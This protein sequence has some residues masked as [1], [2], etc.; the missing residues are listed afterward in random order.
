MVGWTG[1]ACAYELKQ[2]GQAVTVFE[3]SDRVGGR[4]WTLRGAFA[5]KCFLGVHAAWLSSSRQVGC[6]SSANGLP[7]WDSTWAGVIV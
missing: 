1:L 2:A 3:A 7:I 6:W 4:S 5:A